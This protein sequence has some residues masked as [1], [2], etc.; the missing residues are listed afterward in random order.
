MA[1]LADAERCEKAHGA[2]PGALSLVA[3]LRRE[4]PEKIL[5]SWKDIAG[6]LKRD[7]RTVQRWEKSMGLP[8]H[9]LQNSRSGSVFAYQAELDRWRDQRA[10]QMARD[11]LPFAETAAPSPPPDKTSRLPAVW[12]AAAWGALAGASATTI[13]FML[14]H[15]LGRHF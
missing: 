11:R 9:R 2:G 6:Y 10:L 13:L 7:V 14:L 12:L 15:A 4:E 5:E 3:P 8:V 1:F